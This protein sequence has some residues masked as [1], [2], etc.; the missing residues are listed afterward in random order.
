MKYYFTLLAKRC[1]REF[2][3]YKVHPVFIIAVG[4]GLF[5][6]ISWIIFSRLS[7]P[8]F[9]YTGLA[10]WGCYLLG[11]RKRNEFLK[12]LFT[13]RTYLL[14]R[15]T[16]NVLGVLPFVVFMVCNHLFL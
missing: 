14:V 7:Y 1:F 5:T 6:G 4:G 8:E 15:L 16:E 11:G 9:L 3:E 12:R 10:L 2:G 13:L